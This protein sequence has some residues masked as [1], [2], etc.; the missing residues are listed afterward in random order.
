[1]RSHTR[2]KSKTT[3][4]TF[5]PRPVAFV[6]VRGC[7][8]RVDGLGTVLSPPQRRPVA[9]RHSGRVDTACQALGSPF[10]LARRQFVG[11]ALRSQLR[12]AR[13]LRWRASI[14]G[15]DRSG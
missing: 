10:G 13:S 8:G 1:M 5:Y 9:E 3:A 11:S 6:A 2:L 12:V 4:H 15:H 7:Q 14:A